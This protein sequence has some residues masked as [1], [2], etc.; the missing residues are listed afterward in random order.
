MKWVTDALSRHTFTGS[1]VPCI[2]YTAGKCRR[3]A[4]DTE[5]ATVTG[6]T[7]V[8]ACTPF[9]RQVRIQNCVVGL[10]GRLLALTLRYSSRTLRARHRSAKPA[11]HVL[12]R[13]QHSRGRPICRCV[14]FTSLLPYHSAA[15]GPTHLQCCRCCCL[16]RVTISVMANSAVENKV[17]V[18]TGANRGLGL[19]ARSL[20]A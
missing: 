13:P 2:V 1:Q 10:N 20:F 12:C 3:S 14:H 15:Q 4:A 19:E 16:G 5:R 11:V 9:K 17:V 18:V 6:L 7:L 8:D